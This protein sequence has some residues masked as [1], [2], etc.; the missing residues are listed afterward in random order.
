MLA[1]QPN[2]DDR[3]RKSYA[4][5]RL[6]VEASPN[7]ILIVN[8]H[9]RI[10]LVNTQTEKLF[11]Y[12]RS[13]LLDQAVE[14]LVPERYRVT[15]PKY[16]Q[17]FFCMPS[18][19]AMGA[20]RDLFGKRKDG[21]EVPI[22]I[23]LSPL[24]SDDEPLVLASIIDITERKHAEER[25][26][27]SQEQLAGVI[28]SAMDA[29]ITVDEE[30]RI[31]LFNNA[32][33][34]MFLYPAEDAVGMPLN[35]FIPDRFREAHSDHIRNFGQTNVSKRAMG[36]LGAIFGLRADGKEFPIEASISQIESEGRKLF[37]VILRD[38]TQRK[39]A[40]E[41]LREQARILDLAP[42][43]IRDLDDRIVLWNT[44]AEQMYGW[45]R[46]EA[47]EKTVHTLLKTKFPRP[48][49]EIKAKVYA[50]GHWE[51]ELTHSTRA[52]KRIVVASHWVLHR[53]E[54]RKPKAILEVN[55]DITERR[56]AEEE[57]RRL[58]EDLENRV[59]ERTA[60]LQV[61]NKELEAFSYT[62]SHDLRA[63]LRQI[64]G[65]SE[66]LLEDYE[67]QL[68]EQG[69]EFLNELQAASHE[70]SELIDD[71]LELAQVS[72]GAMQHETVDLSAIARSVIAQIRKR[73]PHRSVDVTVEEGLQ[74]RGDM[75]LLEVVLTNLL[76]N[77]WKFTSK[78]DQ[79]VIHFGR[80][81]QDGEPVF[82]IRDN[83]AGFEMELANKLFGE[84]QRL[85]STSDF[86]GTGVGLATVQ[87]IVHRHGGRIW[88]EG[89]VDEGASFYFT[90]P[91]LKRE[92]IEER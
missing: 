85:H 50:R 81:T 92:S 44:G 55:N 38:I 1:D 10:T 47:L 51:G 88:A 4:Q 40:E 11:G 39:N 89:A 49:E 13:E 29:I 31:V 24:D 66:A 75:R 45:K 59:Q 37:T 74:A 15:H 82:F 91:A 12:D 80:Q 14:L 69:R 17:E 8:R 65:F 7:A 71:M 84:F 60:Q 2:A 21:T 5:L 68:D 3:L 25:V 64:H 42:V 30:Q 57:I 34:K 79:P 28:S 72:R 87:R 32:A 16:L 70:M 41:S 58:N 86:E 18:A 43:L 78:R 61:A 67:D 52:G 35:H 56:Q 63:P 90:L 36:A 22:E 62:V 6:I 19:R 20:G 48:L 73:E 83:G 77:A 23:G 76:G 46:E 53:D 27:R 54:Y 26:R 9:G 33:E